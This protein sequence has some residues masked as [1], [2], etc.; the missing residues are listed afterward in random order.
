MGKRVWNLNPGPAVLPE[1]VLEEASKAVL[2]YEGKGMSL[3]EMS[4]RAKEVD[5]IFKDTEADLKEIM[6]LGDDYSVVFMGGGA[7]LQFTMIPMNFLHDDQTA[8]Y[9][10]T[11]SWSQNAIKEAKLLGKVNVAASSEER[12]FTYIP[13]IFDL[14]PDPA[15]LHITT[16]NTI[17]GTQYHFDPDVK[18][19]LIADM[20]SDILSMRRDF[21]KYS[22]IYAG[23]QKNLGPA[24]VTVIIIKKDM[25][26]RVKPGIPTLLSFKTQVEKESLFNTPPVFPTYVVGL[27]AKWIKSQGGLAAIE[28]GNRKKADLLYGCLDEY[29][30][31]YRAP[32]NKEDLSWM[33]VVFRLPSEDLEKKF[34]AEAGEKSLIG[35]KGHRSVGGV[36]ASIYN[37]FP[38]AGVEELV[39]F[40]KAFAKKEAGIGV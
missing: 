32:V 33:N 30:D 9:V 10:N 31:F 22:L 3:M 25:L 17:R 14:S 4:H 40:M 23:A 20:S 37:A 7:S 8:D 39:S 2:E 34:L 16:N 12:E 19:P 1:A 38:Y 11:G 6:G 18:V 26:E 13:K 21:K 27:V 36:R 24:G 29:S 15:Y 35:M 5:K 28:A